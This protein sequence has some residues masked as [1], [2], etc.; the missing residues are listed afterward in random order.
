M[1]RYHRERQPEAVDV[2]GKERGE[3]GRG[4]RGIHR[5]VQRNR[6]FLRVIPG[7]NGAVFYIDLDER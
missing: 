2:R 5:A 7:E 1:R 6:E 4:C 3:H